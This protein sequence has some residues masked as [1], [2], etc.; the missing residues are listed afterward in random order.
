MGGERN[1]TLILRDVNERN[2]IEAD[3]QRL[4][5]ERSYLTKELRSGSR[6]EAIVG[7]SPLLKRLLT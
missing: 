3:L 5:W 4:R 7:E 1:Y 6:F 2:R